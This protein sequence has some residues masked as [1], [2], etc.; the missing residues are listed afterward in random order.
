V[1]LNARQE[2]SRGG[3]VVAK[4]RLNE[5]ARARLGDTCVALPPC[6]F[7]LLKAAPRG[8]PSAGH[9]AKKRPFSVRYVNVKVLG[10]PKAA[11]KSAQLTF[12]FSCLSLQPH[13]FSSRVYCRHRH[14]S[15]YITPSAGIVIIM[16]LSVGELQ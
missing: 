8:L 16:V 9:V 1:F 11:D 15:V 14:R 10:P 13:L 2:R 7:P 6:P 5:V 3:K 12:D 4:P